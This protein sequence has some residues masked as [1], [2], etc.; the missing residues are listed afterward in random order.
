MSAI[1]DN[2]E[3]YFTPDSLR[4]LRLSSTEW[5][6]IKKCP[7][8]SNPL[9]C[10]VKVVSETLYCSGCNLGV[11]SSGC[12]CSSRD[13]DALFVKCS[14][15]NTCKTC[16]GTLSYCILHGDKCERCE[17]IAEEKRQKEKFTKT[18]NSGIEGKLSVYG[19]T[20]LLALARVKKIEHCNFVSTTNK[21]PK[22]N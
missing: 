18:W 7:V 8:C 14:N 10:E 12:S 6:L 22:M 1:T 19:K 17:K 21:G 13:V 3:L 15:C 5:L 9:T 4:N 2:L 16:G 20:K 11:F